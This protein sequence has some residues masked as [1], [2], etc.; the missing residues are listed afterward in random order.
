MRLFILG[1]ALVMFALCATLTAATAEEQKAP[2]AQPQQQDA[3]VKVVRV[4]P[5]QPGE[6]FQELTV[7]NVNVFY[8]EG[9]KDVA[10]QM[11]EKT[12]ALIKSTMALTGIKPQST[13][14][15]TMRPVKVSGEIWSVGAESSIDLDK[16]I[17][18]WPMAVPEGDAANYSFDSI[19]SLYNILHA[20]FNT[21]EMQINLARPGA[22]TKEP[23]WFVRGLTLY[24]MNKAAHE[25]T[26]KI[27][28]K[29][30]NIFY[31][32]YPDKYLE[33]YKAKLLDWHTPSADDL[34]DMAYRVG[35][36]QMFVE[37]EK[38]FGPEAIKKIGEGFAKAEDTDNATLVKIISDAIG[39]DLV[40][41]LN[42]YEAPK[43]PQLGV[44]TNREYKGPGVR[45]SAIMS[46]SAADAAGFAE[47][48]IIVSVNG[49][50]IASKADLVAIVKEAG[51]GGELKAHI[52]RGDQE[53]DLTA[54]VSEPT[55]DFPP[56]PEPPKPEPDKPADK[57]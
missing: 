37:I 15:I 30:A 32:D 18:T 13:C 52:K 9:W 28:D 35:C 55:F 34:A 8:M 50:A 16:K 53:M 7:G 21:C 22:I 14:E 29:T 44:Q 17:V 47:G 1:A 36:M 6:D 51:V 12:D 40:E 45:V 42:K 25:L 4:A 10:K 11:A 38:K 39:T 48:D 57:Y 31:M 33:H 49:K 46:E 41:F 5:H 24:L 23:L 54:T 20:S 56:D 19:D 27:P 43:Y 26:A 3:G 2:E